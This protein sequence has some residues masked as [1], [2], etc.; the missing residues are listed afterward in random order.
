MFTS[1]KSAL[2]AVVPVLLI[3]LG[4]CSRSN[5]G[6]ASFVPSPH[7][8]AIPTN[9]KISI[10]GPGSDNALD[11]LVVAFMVA[12]QVPN[13][14]LAVSVKGMTTFSHAYTYRGLAV[15][16]TTP[17]TWDPLESTCRHASLSIL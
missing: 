8:A 6:N 11:K 9:S 5:G 7:F 16:T 4:A 14:Q 13:A 1:T 17:S 15:S 12:Q 3:A 2:I 10:V